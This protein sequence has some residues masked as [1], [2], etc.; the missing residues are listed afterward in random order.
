MGN[1]I[2]LSETPDKPLKDLKEVN[3]ITNTNAKGFSINRQPKD[4]SDFVIV[5]QRKDNFLDRKGDRVIK[6]SD[7][8]PYSIGGQ[9]D[10]DIIQQQAPTLDNLYSRAKKDNDALGL[11]KSK[12]GSRQP[13]I[14][15]DVGQRWNGLDKPYV[16]NT[17]DIVRGGPLTL[18]GRAAAD[19]E[20]VFEL[21]YEPPRHGRRP[22]PGPARNELRIN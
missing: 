7:T 18:L 4:Q 22:A 3:F 19:T 12:F 15:R 2:P 5:S 20:I 14:I 6:F 10:S 8:E 9:R 1:T 11:R 16:G 17:I 21:C 13:F